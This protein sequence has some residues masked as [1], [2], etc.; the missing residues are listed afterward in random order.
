MSQHNNRFHGRNSDNIA[1][2]KPNLLSLLMHIIRAT[3]LDRM[4][5]PVLFCIVLVYAL[6][7]FNFTHQDSLTILIISCILVIGLVRGCNAW[8]YDLDDYQRQLAMTRHQQPDAEERNT[9]PGFFPT[10]RY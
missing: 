8:Q 5:W 2:V 3:V 6:H 10:R 9:I 7:H 1:V 4:Q